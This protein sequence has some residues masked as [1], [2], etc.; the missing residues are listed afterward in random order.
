MCHTAYTKIQHFIH[1]CSGTDKT[2][3]DPMTLGGGNT[4]K[5]LSFTLYLFFSGLNSH[6][7][8]EAVCREIWE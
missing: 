4:Y 1:V 7:L 2:T 5:I 6:L 3:A 8:T